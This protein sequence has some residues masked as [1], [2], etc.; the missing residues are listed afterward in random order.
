MVRH[1]ASVEAYELS[2]LPP[3]THIGMPSASLTVVISLDDDLDLSG[4]PVGERRAFGVSVAGLHSTPV[5]IHHD[6]QMRGVQLELTPAGS[7]ALLGCPAG[8]LAEQVLE[9]SDVVGVGI[10]RLREALHEAS[11]PADRGR[12]VWEMWGASALAAAM[13]ERL[14]RAWARL[15]VTAGLVSVRELADDSGWSRR[16]FTD[17]FTREFGQGPKTVSRVLRFGRSRA[18]VRHGIPAVEVASRCG[19]A[20]QAHLVREWR[21]L[22]G[23]TPGRW[24]DDDDLAFVQ[25]SDTVERAG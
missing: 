7:R 10:T 18:M 23:T 3:G 24:A 11:T 2:G 6:G 13:D 22:A 25:D 16:H 21:R 8:E 12:L 9:G 14:A 4:A 19:Y 5:T 20:D 1:V 17:R 15:Q